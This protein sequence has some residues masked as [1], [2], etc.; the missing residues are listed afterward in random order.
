ML[1][2]AHWD[3]DDHRD[4]DACI[5][6][7]QAD[8]I[9]AIIAKCTQGK[10]AVDTAWPRWVAACQR[11][12]VLF[13]AYHF[14]SNTADGAAEAD[15]FLEHLDRAGLD[16]AATSRALDFERNPKPNLTMRVAQAEDFAQ[17]VFDR[18]GVWPLLYGDVSFH[19]HITDPHTVLA[20]CPLWVA[21][22]GGTSPKVP[23][24]WA[25]QGWT[26]WQYTD[27]VYSGGG[28]PRGTLGFSRMDR[29]VFKGTSADLRAAW[30]R[31]G[32]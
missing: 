1:D 20:H 27:G 9:T 19:S 4:L 10:D 29:S 30:P 14:A 26:L 18:T 32:G 31:L 16:P 13:G 7:A 28:M 6:Q 17:R 2:V 12:G 8:G 21:Q 3:A 24:A 22:Y 15:W 23:P 5:A 11:A 25:R